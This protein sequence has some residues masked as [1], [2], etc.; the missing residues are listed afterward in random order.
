MP[1]K[2]ITVPVGDNGQ[3]A[4]V[5]ELNLEQVFNLLESVLGNKK[6]SG[7]ND[8]EFIKYIKQMLL[9]NSAQVLDLPD[10]L[11]PMQLT[12]SELTLITQ[13][14]IELH[15]DFFLLMESMGQPIPKPLQ[16]ALK[17]TQPDSSSA[18]T[19]AFG[20]MGCPTTTT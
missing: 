6:L 11:K 12:L 18:V 15:K 1:T 19:A 5:K 17:P 4:T 16:T 13:K 10:G 2:T 8:V 3:F 14:F 20:N 7:A 9:S